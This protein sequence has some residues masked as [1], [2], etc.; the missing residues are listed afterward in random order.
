MSTVPIFISQIV[1]PIGQ[2]VTGKQVNLSRRSVTLSRL[3]VNPSRNPVNLSRSY[4]HSVTQVVN[5]GFIQQGVEGSK[6]GKGNKI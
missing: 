4:G 3:S 1:T 6:K 2:S 5:S